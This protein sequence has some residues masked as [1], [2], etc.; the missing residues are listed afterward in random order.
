MKHKTQS[1]QEKNDELNFIQIKNVCFVQ[2]T[3]KKSKG[4]LQTGRRCLQIT[5]AINDLYQ[6]CMTNPQNSTV[7]QHK[8]LY[9]DVQKT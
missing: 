2:D 1:I 6:D 3:A 5:Y 8:N 9:K 7:R 4:K